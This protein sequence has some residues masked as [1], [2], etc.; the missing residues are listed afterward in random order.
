MNINM[1]VYY[2]IKYLSA[3]V[4]SAFQYIIKFGVL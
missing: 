3:V 4:I 1:G 2:N